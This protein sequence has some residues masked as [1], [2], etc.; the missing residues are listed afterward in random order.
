MCIYIYIYIYTYIYTYT[1]IYTHMLSYINA[2]YVGIKIHG[3][4]KMHEI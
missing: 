3:K 4:S 2:I 1:R